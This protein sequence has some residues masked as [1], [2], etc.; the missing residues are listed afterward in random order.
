MVNNLRKEKD[1]FLLGT[2]PKY[3]G[4]ASLFSVRERE[5]ERGK[6]RE[7]EREREKC[8]E[9]EKMKEMKTLKH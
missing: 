9:A 6:E 5:R 1:R 4:C 8:L 7:R 3:L 2:E